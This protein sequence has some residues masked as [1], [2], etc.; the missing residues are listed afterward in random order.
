LDIQRFFFA[1]ATL[2]SFQ[3]N[4]FPL[5]QSKKRFP[6]PQSKKG[7]TAKRK[8][9]CYF[10]IFRAE[11]F[12]ACF[13]GSVNTISSL[14]LTGFSFFRTGAAFFAVFFAGEADFFLAGT[15]F[16]GDADFLFAGLAVFLS[17]FRRR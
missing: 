17:I 7:F 4:A 13:R 2:S 9:G 8:P 14:S 15:D 6:S 3:K 1:A 5:R 10:I 11:A 16:F 12:A